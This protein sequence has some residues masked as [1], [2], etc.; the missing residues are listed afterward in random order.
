MNTPLNDQSSERSQHPSRGRRRGTALGV[1]AGVLGGGAVGLILTLPGL[2]SAATD[3]TSTTEPVTTVVA[4]SGTIDTTDTTDTTG[5]APDRGARL[6][7]VLQSLVDDGTI[8]ATQADAVAEHL[9]TSMPIGGGGHGGH[10]RHGG[11]GAGGQVVADALGIDVDTLRSELQAGKTIA[12]IAGEQG[13]DVQA[14]IDALVAEAT[15]RVGEA[16]TDGRLTQEEADARL[17][18]L[19]TRITDRVN[20]GGPLGERRMGAGDHGHMGGFGGMADA[21]DATDA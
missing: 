4:D 19:T 13:V 11:F 9:A 3:S 2:T 17:A 12:E 18:D 10:G 5:T 14:V 7:E 6:R 20:N 21:D 15:E 1:A 8:T 16:V